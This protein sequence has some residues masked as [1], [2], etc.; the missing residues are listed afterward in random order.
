VSGG[1]CHERQGHFKNECP[2]VACASACHMNFAC[3]RCSKRICNGCVSWCGWCHDDTNWCVSCQRSSECP[4]CQEYVWMEHSEVCG[5]CSSRLCACC[6]SDGDVTMF[7]CG[8]CNG[9]FCFVCM[10]MCR[11]CSRC[12]ACCDC[13]ED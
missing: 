10:R 6:I 2:S 1:A 12:T 4:R 8:N 11:Q 9:E 13:D 5:R 3:A 7:I